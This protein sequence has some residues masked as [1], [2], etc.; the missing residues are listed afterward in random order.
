MQV[1]INLNID[2]RIVNFFKKTFS[3]K[4]SFAILIVALIFGGAALYAATTSP[5]TDFQPGQAISASEFNQR[6][7]QIA[8]HYKEDIAVT[9]GSGGD[10]VDFDELKAWLARS[11][12]NPDMWLTIKLVSDQNG[13]LGLKGMQNNISIDLNGYNITSTVGGVLSFYG[14]RYVVIANYNASSTSVLTQ[15]SEWGSCIYSSSNSYVVVGNGKAGDIV[16]SS[17]A[18]RYRAIHASNGG[19]ILVNP[20][21]TGAITINDIYKS[22][23]GGAGLFTRMGKIEVVAG[24]GCVVINNGSSGIGVQADRGSNIFIFSTINI[25]GSGDDYSPN[26]GTVGNSNAYIN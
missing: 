18:P 3:K 13:Y 16:L 11:T 7:N 5:W 19:H 25:T 2:D 6:F 14:C 17:T 10:F 9:L 12:F 15:G 23:S 21:G 1:N 8:K 24:S 26:R 4:R 22:A 20:S